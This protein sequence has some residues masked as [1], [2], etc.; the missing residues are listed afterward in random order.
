VTRPEEV[1]DA[2]EVAPDLSA[3]VDL[4]LGQDH[5]RRLVGA[6]SSKLHDHG[7]VVLGGGLR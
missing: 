2:S 4:L 6:N 3:A 1:A 5:R 7:G